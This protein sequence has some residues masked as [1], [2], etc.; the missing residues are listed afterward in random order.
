MKEAAGAVV[1]AAMIFMTGFVFGYENCEKSYHRAID[2]V[3][4]QIE[5][6]RRES[7]KILAEAITERDSKLSQ[8]RADAD[9]LRRTVERLRRSGS[10]G[11]GYASND[12][13]IAPKA[14][15]NECKRLLGEGL[16]LLGEGGEML[17]RNAAD[18]DALIKTH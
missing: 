5:E 13:C 15:L 12:P 17:R 18:H 9:S 6:Q 8:L 7:E 16:E 10:A 3:K 14:A 1:L 4:K 11:G 2:T